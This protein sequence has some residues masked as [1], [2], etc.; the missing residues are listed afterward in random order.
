MTHGST[1]RGFLAAAA[2]AAAALAAGCASHSEKIA[3]FREA[4]AAD[5][6]NGAEAAIDQLLASET[7]A[8]LETVQ[9]SKAL[10]PAVNATS[11]NTDLLLLE[12]AMVRLAQGDP[13][14]SVKVFL[15]ARDTLDKHLE[16]SLKGTLVEFLKGGLQDDEGME[17]QGADYEHVMIRVLLT[18]TDLLTG[19][20]DA[21]AY[22]NQV[23]ETQDAIINSPFG[24]E[25]KKYYPRKQYQRMAVGAY[26][27]GVIQEAN[28]YSSEAALAYERA[29]GWVGGDAAAAAPAP[30]GGAPEVVAAAVANRSA[31]TVLKEALQ[32]ARDG[33]YAPDGCG[34]I[35]IFYFGGRGP[36][37]EATTCNPTA[38]AVQLAA[39]GYSIAT[40]SFAQL[41]QMPV[42]V[43]M[44]VAPDWMVPPLPVS[45][46]G[47]AAAGTTA[48]LLDVNV[49]AKQQLAANMPGISARAVIRRAVK[50]A[51]GGAIEAQ[52][53]DYA[54]VLGFLFTAISTGTERAE[55]RNWVSLP[56]QLQ[57]ARVPAMEGE[58]RL[59]FGP[60]METLVRIAKGH[61]TYVV[62]LRPNLALPGVVLVDRASRVEPKAPAPVP[63]PT[64]APQGT[65]SAS[66]A[67]A[68]I[69][70]PVP[71]P[72]PA[73]APAVA[74][75]KK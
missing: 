28:L 25:K 55:T 72:A 14:G 45:V 19:E 4:W 46:D 49:V 21:F 67:V 62:V 58:R 9:K 11:G 29:L 34:V 50:G 42:K 17:F 52:G 20:G 8:P 47:A 74:P 5:D 40:S 59:S 51:V 65:P 12:K 63:A 70:A 44:V 43:P 75:P 13:S 31:A 64:A 2:L 39:I 22:A 18:V 27:Q 36:H 3:A 60:G 26:V 7:G 6:F 37:L 15:K 53:S 41:G 69:P 23:G 54:K 16:K 61:D 32:R 30:V 56:A 71:A 57:V 24:D 68:P 38:E 10:D 35:H 33:K 73:P 66:P 1:A 48:T